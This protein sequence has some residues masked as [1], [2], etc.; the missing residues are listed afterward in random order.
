MAETISTGSQRAQA[1]S[2]K[3]L[4]PSYGQNVAIR[5]MPQTTPV[6]S[7]FG[8]LEARFLQFSAN[9]SR[10][11][12][13]G[14]REL[15]PKRLFGPKY[16]AVPLFLFPNLQFRYIYDY[17]SQ[18]AKSNNFGYTCAMA[19]PYNVTD[20]LNCPSMTRSPIKSNNE[21]SVLLNW[22]SETSY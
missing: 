4:F 18:W 17:H 15:C 13:D 7:R 1:L 8:L 21:A 10:T 12:H 22:H 14:Q 5:F 20:L 9:T 2:Q 19:R 11:T 3:S 16:E 6:P